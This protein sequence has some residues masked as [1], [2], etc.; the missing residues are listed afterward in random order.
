MV[1]SGT[2]AS[3]GKKRP[4]RELNLPVVISMNTALLIVATSYCIKFCLH[5][6]RAGTEFSRF[7][8]PHSRHSRMRNHTTRSEREVVRRNTIDEEGRVAGWSALSK[9]FFLKGS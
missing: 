9:Q 8:G 7:D 2:T 5:V 1:L 4:S 3:T 6:R